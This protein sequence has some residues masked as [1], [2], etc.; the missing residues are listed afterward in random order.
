MNRTASVLMSS[1]GVRGAGMFS[2]WPVRSASTVL[3]YSLTA[4]TSQPKQRHDQGDDADEQQPLPEDEAEHEHR[5]A[6]RAEE[7]PER[8]VRACARRAAVRRG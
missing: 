1:V 3:R 4:S 6:D 5:H 7:R 2:R 8:R